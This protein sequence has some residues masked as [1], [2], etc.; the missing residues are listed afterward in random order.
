M[1]TLANRRVIRSN[2]ADRPTAAR[3]SSA[4][5]GLSSES[6]W[7]SPCVG[8]KSSMRL[9]AIFALSIL[10]LVLTFSS[11]NKTVEDGLLIEV[12][13]L[14]YTTPE[15]LTDDS[16]YISSVWLVYSISVPRNKTGLERLSMMEFYEEDPSGCY[17]LIRTT[18]FPIYCPHDR[19]CIQ[20]ASVRNTNAPCISEH[21][22]KEITEAGLTLSKGVTIRRCSDRMAI[23]K[24]QS[25][26]EVSN[27]IYASSEFKHPPNPRSCECQTFAGPVRVLADDQS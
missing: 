24:A 9:T 25:F 27:P 21:S 1:F 6:R 20:V 22:Y 7:K 5:V 17:P 11:C 10:L 3:A 13:K 26:F 14:T 15:V 12:Q 19:Y 16:L 4:G 2:A 8:L 18:D 23:S